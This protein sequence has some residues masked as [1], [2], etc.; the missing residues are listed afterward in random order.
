MRREPDVLVKLPSSLLSASL[1]SGS[2]SDDIISRSKNNS[3]KDVINDGRSNSNNDSSNMKD[4]LLAA[5]NPKNRK[6]KEEKD[7]IVSRKLSRAMIRFS[8]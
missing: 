8:M 1:T 6:R 4:D 5:T 7:S 2:N 3:I